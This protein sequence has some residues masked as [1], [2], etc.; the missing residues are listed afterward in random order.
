MP[1]QK[2]TTTSSTTRRSGK[3]STRKT[4]PVFRTAVSTGEKR[5]TFQVSGGYRLELPDGKGRIQRVTKKRI[6][7]VQRQESTSAKFAFALKLDEFSCEDEAQ[8]QLRELED[9]GY[10]TRIYTLGRKLEFGRFVHDN[11]RYQ[12]IVGCCESEED[13]GKLQ[14]ELNRYQTEIFR[15]RI[16]EPVG[17]FEIFDLEYDK[18]TMVDNVARLIPETPESRLTLL[19][20]KVFSGNSRVE[21]EDLDFSGVIEFRVENGGLMLAINEVELDEY[22]LSVLAAEQDGDYPRE[23]LKAKAIAVRSLALAELSLQHPWDDYDFCAHDHCQ[24]YK[25]VTTVHDLQEKAVSMTRGR[26]LLYEKQVA[27]TW[28]TTVCG[29]HLETGEN[30]FAIPPVK[31]LPGLADKSDNARRRKKVNL[32]IETNACEWIKSEPATCCNV[33]QRKSQQVYEQSRRYYRWQEAYQRR[34]LEDVITRRTGVE[35]GTLYEIIPIRRGVS[36]RIL[37]L[38]IIGSR[39]NVMVAG[40]E[41]VRRV[42]SNTELLSSCF[43]IEVEYTDLNEPLNFIIHGAGHGHGVGMCETGAGTLAAEKGFKFKEILEHYYTGIEVK[44]IYG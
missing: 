28:Y 9:Q 2:K 36:G 19:K 15:E 31:Y 14:Q 8:L 10:E 26:V 1:T 40:D 6:W 32:T 23:A 25:G 13:I 3:S 24:K 33:T 41:S 12:V 35:I 42:L 37:E 34:E 4:V 17:R 30:V 21:R 39:N 18:H 29:G 5:M 44:K 20:T 27:H 16:E 38:E 22:V 11:R 7:R 43:Y